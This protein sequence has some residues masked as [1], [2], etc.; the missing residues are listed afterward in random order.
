[1]ENVPFNPVAVVDGLVRDCASRPRDCAGC[2]R[3]SDLCNRMRS[4]MASSFKILPILCNSYRR[5]SRGTYSLAC[6]DA[7]AYPTRLVQLVVR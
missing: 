2:N 5:A 1:M 7:G 6:S 3:S 4:P